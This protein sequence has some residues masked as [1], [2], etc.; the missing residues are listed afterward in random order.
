MSAP[1]VADQVGHRTGGADP[2]GV[3]GYRPRTAWSAEHSLL[4]ESVEQ[5]RGVNR[6]QSCHRNP[7][8]GHDDLF[9]GAG[10][11]DPT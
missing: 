1:F 5:G 3:A 2:E 4:G 10:P 6:N 9:P 7:A 11:F 8:V